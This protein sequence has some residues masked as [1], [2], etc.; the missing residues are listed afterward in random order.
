MVITQ[1]I[2]DGFQYLG[3]AD[4]NGTMT[5]LYVNEPDSYTHLITYPAADIGVCEKA[6]GTDVVQL[7]SLLLHELSHHYCPVTV[8]REDCATA[9]QIA[10]DDDL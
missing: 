8:G 6:C 3:E 9:A 5:K 1:Y 7:A 2:Y 10:C 4:E